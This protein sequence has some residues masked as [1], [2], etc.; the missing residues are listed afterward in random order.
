MHA[1]SPWESVTARSILGIKISTCGLIPLISHSSA[2]LSILSGMSSPL[3]ISIHYLGARNQLRRPPDPPSC[4]SSPPL[5]G[6]RALAVRNLSPLRPFL[7][8]VN[9]RT[10]AIAQDTVLCSRFAQGA[11]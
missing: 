9:W 5:E 4:L 7:L 11:S 3:I 6:L 1:W 2:V 8:L 10:I